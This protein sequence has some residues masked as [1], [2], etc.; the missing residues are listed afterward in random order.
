MNSDIFVVW[1]KKSKD[2][3]MCLGLIYTGTVCTVILDWVW[4]LLPLGVL[5]GRF[6]SFDFF[7]FWFFVFCFPFCFSLFFPR[8]YN[9]ISCICSLLIRL[10]W[11]DLVSLTYNIG[12]ARMHANAKWIYRLETSKLRHM[13][14]EHSRMRGQVRF[15]NFF[16]NFFFSKGSGMDID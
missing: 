7:F 2:A 5:L 4:Q 10:S 16:S 1:N 9:L 11:I 6:K 3:K 8:S 15:S 12:S 14:I 13:H